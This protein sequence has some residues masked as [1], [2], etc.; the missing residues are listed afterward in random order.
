MLYLWPKLNNY[1]C[2]LLQNWKKLNLNVHEPSEVSIL[3]CIVVM[4]WDFKRISG[5]FVWLFLVDII[6]ECVTL[7]LP[8]FQDG[9]FWQRRVRSWSSKIELYCSQNNYLSS[10]EIFI[11]DVIYFLQWSMKRVQIWNPDDLLRDFCP[12]CRSSEDF[13]YLDISKYRWFLNR[14][15]I[16]RWKSSEL[17]STYKL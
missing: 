4:V 12:N 3:S 1:D 8:S 2:L 11:L 17:V 15:V 7:A 14:V 6:N 13:T 16:E 5:E 9:G 10:F